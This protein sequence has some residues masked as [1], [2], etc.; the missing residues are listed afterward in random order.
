[1]TTFKDLGLTE[2]SLRELD[3]VGFEKPTEIQK[4]VIQEFKNS[5]KNI[6]GE[7][8]TG[9][10]KTLAF[11]LPILENLQEGRH[12]IQTIILTPTRELAVQVAEQIIKFKGDKKIFISTIYGG[13]AISKEARELSKGVD[14]V[15][16]T[17]GRV[18]DHINNKRMDLSNIKYFVL[19]EFDEMLRMGFIEDV[20][21]ILSQA[22]KSDPRMLFFSATVPLPIKRIVT[23]YMKEYEHIKVKDDG[24]YV[25]TI[26]QLYY[27]INEEDKLEVL[28]R[29]LSSEKDFYG[30][31]FCN[32][33]SDVDTLKNNLSDRGFNVEG[34]HGEV[35]QKQRELKLQSF[36]KKKVKILI[37]TDVAARGIDVNDLTCVINYNLPERPEEYKHRIGRTGRAGKSGTAHTFVTR[38]DR[39]KIQRFQGHFGDVIKKG[40]IPTQKDIVNRKIEQIENDIVLEAIKNSD[41]IKE[42]SKKLLSKNEPEQIIAYLLTQ[43]IGENEISNDIIGNEDIGAYRE[44]RSSGGS[45]RGFRGSRS[46]GRNYDRGS[47]YSSSRGSSEGRRF[48]R[49]DKGSRDNSSSRGSSEGRRFSRD[50]RG[51]RDNSS[52]RGS[53][54]GRRFSRDDRGSR[55][56]SSS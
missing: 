50:D 24:D 3:K 6:L 44:G 53:S 2:N 42:I 29:I 26:K 28:I 36:K 25:S 54:E 52:S 9:S 20:D 22:T 39:L 8:K 27:N 14:I 1:M 12:G 33:R 45:S 31:I 38:W 51:S 30:M 16:G 40:L 19:D 10:G 34:I 7:S 35:P 13:Q 56:N 17:P 49:D 5:S 46:G 11:G 21:F 48:S 4:L 41:Q 47:R 55:D 23:K 32:K 15:V 43:I 37:C 18:I